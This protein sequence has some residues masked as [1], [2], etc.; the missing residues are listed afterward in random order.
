ML[1]VVIAPVTKMRR[2]S[3][4]RELDGLSSLYELV[5]GSEISCACSCGSESSDFRPRI[6]KNRNNDSL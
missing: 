4:G 3:K 2:P 5:A 6:D 1:E